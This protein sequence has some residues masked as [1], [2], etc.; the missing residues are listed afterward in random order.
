MWV[1]PVTFDKLIQWNAGHNP[2]CRVTNC[3]PF[4][5]LEVAA[6]YLLRNGEG[7]YGQQR[8]KRQ[9]RRINQRRDEVY[10]S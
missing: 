2:F 9:K 3:V 6:S 7:K 10:N 8:P 5:K 1:V 4:S